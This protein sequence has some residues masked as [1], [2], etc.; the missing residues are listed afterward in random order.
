MSNR[1][2]DADT[3][4]LA[5]NGSEKAFRVIY[6]AYHPLIRF[7]AG[8][9]GFTNGA[10]DDVVQETF[11]RL[12]K[13]LASIDH[14]GAIKSWV[15][16]T[17]KNYMIDLMRSQKRKPEDSV[18][19]TSQ[20]EKV[21]VSEAGENSLLR[22]LE[23]KLVGE[24]IDDVCRTSGDDTFALFYKEGWTAKQIAEK[25]GEAVSTVTTR[26][27]RLRKKFKESLTDEIQNLRDKHVG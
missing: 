10:V 16:R 4:N 13:N 22:E 15:I 14:E 26:I 12:F 27:S 18:A 8:Q 3:L 7:I 2:I 19:E 21:D 11:I 1:G 5:K 6:D 24:L 23:V 20:L 25:K 9:L 17:S